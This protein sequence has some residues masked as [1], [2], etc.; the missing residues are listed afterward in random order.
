MKLLILGPDS[1]RAS[2]YIR[3][4]P[5]NKLIFIDHPNDIERYILELNQLGLFGDLS[6]YVFK[7]VLI[8]LEPHFEVILKT[9]TPLIIWEEKDKIDTRKKNIKSFI[10]I[11]DKKMFLPL[12][13]P[14]ATEWLIRNGN[15]L[16]I[17]LRRDSA[18]MLID[19]HGLDAGTLENELIKLALYAKSQDTHL[20]E[21]SHVSLLSQSNTEISIFDILDNILSRKISQAGRQLIDYRKRNQ[22]EWYFF[23]MLVKQ[24][25]MLLQLSYGIQ[26]DGHP[27]VIQKIS[28]LTKLWNK[29]AL[30]DKYTQLLTIELKVKKGESELCPELT[31]WL[32]QK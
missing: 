5:G 29:E 17:E 3:S 26:P 28:K 16:N 25:R 14:E 23:V 2:K 24:M 6:L 8:H 11:L 22:D 13:V 15:D 30:A 20:I 27:F 12:T 9:Q 19:Y 4:L 31:R 18:R 10:D 7:N 1:Y 32:Y 21:P